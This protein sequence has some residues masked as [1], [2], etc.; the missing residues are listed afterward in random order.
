MIGEISIAASLL[1][2]LF[3]V[4]KGDKKDKSDEVAG[5]E[6]FS[7]LMGQAGIDIQSFPVAAKDEDTGL[8]A[9]S[10]DKTDAAAAEAFQYIKDM[11]AGGLEG[12]MRTAMQKLRDK[13]MEEMGVSDE[14]LAVMDP[15]A[16][17][18]MEAKI[19]EEVQ[20]R[21]KEAMGAD[22]TVTAE[23]QMVGAKLLELAKA[24]KSDISV[25]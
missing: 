3:D 16:R 25:I 9:V 24:Y 15:A 1:G 19:S 14:S 7:A 18:E 4:A 21:I 6:E 10:G 23:E 8:S 11:T 12:A 2:K 13:I 20:K 17:G 22:G 5:S